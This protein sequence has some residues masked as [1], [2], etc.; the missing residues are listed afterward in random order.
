MDAVAP[1]GEWQ[2]NALRKLATND[3]YARILWFTFGQAVVS[4]LLTLLLALPA[5]Y[6][7]ATFL[8]GSGGPMP[9]D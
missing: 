7:F 8:L 9:T 4:T 1:E 2:L 6:V 3:Y 5:A